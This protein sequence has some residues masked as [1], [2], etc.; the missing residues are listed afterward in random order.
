MN[1]LRPAPFGGRPYYA[2][3]PEAA[4]KPSGGGGRGGPRP[5]P[6]LLLIAKIRARAAEGK[7]FPRKVEEYSGSLLRWIGH[8]ED[9]RIRAQVVQRLLSFHETRTFDGPTMAFLSGKGGDATA[10][11]RLLYTQILI[12]QYGRDGKELSGLI[13]QGNPDEEDCLAR[14]ERLLIEAEKGA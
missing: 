10:W 11:V 1:P 8:V 6:L 4:R 9:S 14:A 7:L 3:P 13:H 5:D 2:R 12:L